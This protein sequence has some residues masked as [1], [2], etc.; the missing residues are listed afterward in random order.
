MASV[1]LNGFNEIGG[2]VVAALT[3][4]RCRLKRCRTELS[5]EPSVVQ[6]NN[7]QRRTTKATA[8]KASIGE[9]HH[10]GWGAIALHYTCGR[11]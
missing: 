5:G 10:N 3:E 1:A 8:I 6:P 4:R 7:N 2:Q 11:V 9:T